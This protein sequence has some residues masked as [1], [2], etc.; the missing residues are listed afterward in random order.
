V[1]VVPAAR[2]AVVFGSRHPGADD[3]RMRPVTGGRAPVLPCSRRRPTQG[4]PRE[5]L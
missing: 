1:Q 4:E 2:H 5:R 3:A